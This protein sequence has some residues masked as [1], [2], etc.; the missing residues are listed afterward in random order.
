MSKKLVFDPNA[1]EPLAK[2]RGG[3]IVTDRIAVE[4]RRIG[5]MRRSTPLN[6]RD[7]GW[8]FFAGNESPAYLADTDKSSVFDLNTLANFDP[9][10]VPYLDAPIGCAFARRGRSASLVQV[11]GAAWKPGTPV[12]RWPPPGFPLV[13]GDQPL[14]NNWSI[15][16]DQPFARRIDE[17]SLV[18]WRPGMTLWIA[19]WSNEHGESRET[20][21]RAF[22]ER[23]SPARTAEREV[24]AAGLTRFDYRLRE[25]RAHGIVESLDALILSDDGHLQVSVYFDDPAEE[26]LARQLV[27]SVRARRAEHE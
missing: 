3:C 4:G 18:L 15:R 12:R 19:A 6:R 10:I 11:E 17:G 13:D 23:A 7:S 14:G 24:T 1:K 27:D 16:L 26:S 5:L 25:A 8:Q 2:G 22:E 20:R 21:L 9:A